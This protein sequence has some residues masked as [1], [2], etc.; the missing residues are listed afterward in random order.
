MYKNT[1]RAGGNTAKYHL[2]PLLLLTSSYNN[3]MNV[4]ARRAEKAETLMT[5]FMLKP[6]LR[7]ISAKLTIMKARQKVSAKVFRKSEKTYVKMKSSI[8]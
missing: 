8:E 3:A 7:R 5:L 2:S 4:K 1:K 6:K